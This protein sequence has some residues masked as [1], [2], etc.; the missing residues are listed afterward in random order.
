[1]AWTGIRIRQYAVQ[2]GMLGLRAAGLRRVLQGDT[3]I[4]EVLSV[5][6]EVD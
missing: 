4:E 5:A 2:S 3:T 6:A 1:M